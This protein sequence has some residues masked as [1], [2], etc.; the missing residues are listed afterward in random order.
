MNSIGTPGPVKSRPVATRDRL[1]GGDGDDFI[2]GNQGSDTAFLGAGNDTFQWDPGDGSDVVEG[3]A[4]ND[5]M[6][7]NGSAG[8]EK[9]EAQAN[10]DHL[11]FTRELI[12]LRRQ[13]PALRRGQ[14]NVFHVHNGNRVIAFHRWI[15]G[16][17]E[18][19]M[20]HV[21]PAMANA[22]F[23]ITGKRVRSLPFKNHDL[24]WS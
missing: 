14:I 12:A 5:K 15:E 9:F 22:V 19:A 3:G 11:R 1:L 17:G 13:L 2:D 16:V 18:E 4:G 20:A 23:Q 7:F 24:S 6:I 10:G 8:N 21:A